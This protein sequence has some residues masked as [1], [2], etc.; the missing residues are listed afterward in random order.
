MSNK[1]EFYGLPSP[2]RRQLVKDFLAKAGYPPYSELEVM[3]HFAW[4]QPQREWQ[5]T[6]MEIAVKFA[7]KAGPELIDLSEWMITHKS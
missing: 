2:L 5:Y 4:E 6:A 7:P 3:V 1:S